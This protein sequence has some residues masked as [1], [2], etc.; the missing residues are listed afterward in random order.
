MISK[1][2]NYAKSIFCVGIREIKKFSRIS[3]ALILCAASLFSAEMLRTSVNTFNIY[4]GN[5]TTS[6]HTVRG[7]VQ[8]ALNCV[9]LQSEDYSVVYTEK[10]GNV[11]NVR[12]EYKFPVYIILKDSYKTVKTKSATVAEIL[13]NAGF[14]PNEYDM[15]EPSL[16]T[17]I[18]EETFIYYSDVEY[19]SG[20]YTE[21]IPYET[22]TVYSSKQK[23]G[24]NTVIAG[25][26]GKKQINY[27]NKVVDGKVVE[28]VVDDTIVLAE[29]K[30]GKKIVGTASANKT[31]KKTVKK[32]AVK[33]SE[34]VKSVSRLTP[35]T[36]IKLDKNGNPVNYKKKI[37]TGA[38]GYTYTG[39]KCATGV[40]P[41]PG[42]IAVNPRVIPY[43]TK[44]YIKTTDG[45][46]IYGYA[47]AADTGGFVRSR[48]N[49][50]DLFFST[51]SA[52]INFGRR[53]VEIYI[54]E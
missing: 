42:Y 46:Y 5:T 24:V 51:R 52:C 14:S 3:L 11:T 38:T 17:L 47:V 43:G 12:V 2:S 30:N 41:K 10:S 36:P 25:T 16:D 37:T 50:V 40:T 1:M 22:K 13:R 53:D 31:V 15:A 23:K 48:P 4:D 32:Q 44:M 6:V 18:T 26:E 7:S 49:N 20:S 21:S 8:A 34:S 19:V 9:N 29:A 54:L 45:A 27:T 39:H 35:E 33:T 28:T